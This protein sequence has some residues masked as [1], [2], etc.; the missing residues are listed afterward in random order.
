M[1]RVVTHLNAQDLIEATLELTPDLAGEYPLFL[2]LD[3][4]KLSLYYSK[5]IKAL[6]EVRDIKKP[7]SVSPEGLSFLLQSGLVP[8]PNTIYKNIFTLG[9]GDKALIR[10][11]NGKIEIDYSHQFPFMNANRLKENEILPD[12]NLILELLANAAISRIDSSQPTYLFQS[13]G[14]DSNTVLLALAKAGW[15]DKI[16]CVCQKSTG[17][18]DESEISKSIAEK[19]GFQHIILEQPDRIFKKPNHI[20][21]YIDSIVNHFTDTPLP[22]TDEVTLAFPSYPLQ[23]PNF[24]GAN[25]IDGSGGDVFLSCIP[26]ISEYRKQLLSNLTWPFARVVDRMASASV[27][28]SIRKTRAEWCGLGGF[29]FAEA[30]AIYPLATP[31]LP[32]WSK[33]S[34]ARQSWDYL[35]FRSDIR[36]SIIDMCIFNQKIR[37]AAD[38]WGSNI[39]FPW[40][41]SEVATYCSKLPE[42]Y[43]FDRTTLKNKLILRKM[44][45]ENLGL[46]SDVIGKRGYGI[47][48]LAI[49]NVL[50]E[51]VFSE[52]TTCSY[53]NRK[54]AL[55]QAHNLRRIAYANGKYYD[56]ARKLL[57][58]LY[59]LSTWLNHNRYIR[60]N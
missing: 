47:D 33:Q 42:K 4:K 12:E 54:A 8:P 31:V 58:R 22:W 55:K 27:F 24:R 3:E 14:K 17:I 10:A 5:S 43:L 19:L 16:I 6:L 20:A 51:H 38:V 35:D 39:I 52:I 57:Q 9:I 18:N 15:R 28:S 60:P 23:L 40:S 7:L 59:L 46:N 36:A 30:K 49:L 45:N 11:K 34:K 56:L 2:Y 29:L 41:N 21:D 32:Y 25:I 13:A 44:L 53:W 37:N 50:M 26:S 48:T 1:E